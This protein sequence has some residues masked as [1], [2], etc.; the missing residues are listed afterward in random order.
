MGIF[1]FLKKEKQNIENTSEELGQMNQSALERNDE[2]ISTKI[3]EVDKKSLNLDSK[4][5]RKDFIND[6][7][8]RIMVASRQIDETKVEY[9]AVTSYLTDMQKID[10]IPKDERQNIDD[11]ARR[12]ITLTRDR[13]KYQNSNNKI[14]D[15]QYRNIEK[16]ED[17]MPD[18]LKKMKENEDYQRMIKN[19][20][21][22]LEGEKGVLKF[23]KEEIIKKQQYLKGLAVVT[24]VLVILLFVLFVAIEKA[25]QTNIQLP[26]IL[27]ILMGTVSAV[28]IYIEARKNAYNMKVV[29]LKQNKAIDLLNSVKIKYINNT[30]VLDYSYNKYMVNN[31]QELS[32]LWEQYIKAKDAAKRYEKNTELLNFYN[33]TLIKELKKYQ[34]EDADIWIY[35][36]IAII[37]QKEM[38]EV[39]HRLNVRRQKLRER[40][41]YN[42]QVKERS[43]KEIKD[44]LKKKPN[45]KQEVVNILGT[46]QIDIEY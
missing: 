1:K 2:E 41:D 37:D 23:Q 29:G 17:E 19:D 33:E 11:A 6:H 12:I 46:Y 34:V 25:F 5:D 44:L 31:Y 35:Q 21:R 16:Y 27:T 8:E 22:H 24:C 13:A 26:F 45:I 15:K 9:Q 30:S 32:Y 39:R 38:V 14:T 3:D 10:M 4:E 20:M 7:C 40:I 18:E 42:N 28:Y 36:A 43:L